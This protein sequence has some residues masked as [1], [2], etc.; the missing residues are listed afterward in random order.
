MRKAARPIFSQTLQLV[1]RPSVV[2]G[3]EILRNAHLPLHQIQIAAAHSTT[4]V[5]R[6]LDPSS[7][8]LK[9]WKY[10]LRYFSGYHNLAS[11]EKELD[12][13]ALV[14]EDLDVVTQRIRDYVINEVPI[15]SNAADYFFRAGV[16]G[17]RLRPTVLLLMASALSVVVPPGVV[18]SAA[19]VD[20]LRLRQ[21][22]IAEVTEMIHVASLLH[23]DVIDKATTRRGVGALN[24]VMG[25][26]VAILAGDFLLARAS[27]RLAN[28]HNTE[29]VELLSTVIDHLVKGEVMQLTSSPE[30]LLSFEHYT[31]KT[32]YKTASLFA[33]S[34]KAVAIL[35]GHSAETVAHSYAYGNHLGLAFQL[36][37]DVLDFTSSSGLLGKPALNDLRS[38]LATAPVL[39]AA[40]EFP[41]LVPMIKRKFKNDG[42]VQQAELWVHKS[43]GI[44]RTRDLASYHCELA[45]ASVNALPPAESERQEECRRALL[46]LTEKVLVRVK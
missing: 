39:Y 4:D 29:V 24:M 21:Q 22:R 38:G 5:R 13:F 42:D 31:E 46:Q 34:L 41:A 37:D 15:L 6:P 44:Q 20:S 18:A 10:S 43:Q 1:S 17:K 23:D 40:E 45:A 14:A 32:F 9:P 35:G 7:R 2:S 28:L 25:N 27:I 19:F 30:S 8:S 12:P 16:E 26:K 3:G 36:V 11:Q 33:H